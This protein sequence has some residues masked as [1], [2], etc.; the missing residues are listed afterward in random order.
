[1]ALNALPQF[2]PPSL[3]LLNS[4]STIFLLFLTYSSSCFL[5][6]F[7]LL[8]MELFKIVSPKRLNLGSKRLFRS[9]KERSAVSRSDP[10]SFSSGVTSSSFCDASVS[11]GKPGS[12]DGAGGLGTPTSVLPEISGDWSDILGDMYTE[13]VQAFKLIDKDKDGFVSRGELEAFLSRLGPERPSGKEV[14]TMLSEVDQDGEGSISV[15]A[16][17]SRIGSAWEPAG[18][19]ELKE[20]FDFFDADRDGKI[21]ADELLQVF[22]ALGDDRCTLEDCRR[23]AAEV[24]GNGDGFVCFEDFVRMMEPQSRS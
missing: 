6:S 18:A 15:E 11:N 2:N 17:M 8:S 20:A 16:L 5:I 10:S 3:L 9:K 14:A 13:L 21:T 24:S 23:M 4:T 7:L 12:G 22:T 19:D 1:M